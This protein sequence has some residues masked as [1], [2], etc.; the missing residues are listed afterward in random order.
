MC[1]GISMERHL[2]WHRN[3][4][5]T[6]AFLSPAVTMPLAAVFLYS[7]WVVAVSSLYIFQHFPE[8]CK[9]RQSEFCHLD[10]VCFT[11]QNMDTCMHV[12]ECGCTL[13]A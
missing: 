1:V 6:R 2:G 8:H 5:G 13:A 10:H 12:L 3:L 7:M 4:H 9:V 11:H